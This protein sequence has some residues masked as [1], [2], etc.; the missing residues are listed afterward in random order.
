[1]TNQYK[2][3]KKYYYTLTLR[4]SSEKE[5]LHSS[6]TNIYLNNMVFSKGDVFIDN[7]VTKKGRCYVNPKYFKLY[8]GGLQCIL[9]G[10]LKLENEKFN[11]VNIGT[12]KYCE[13]TT[14]NNIV[15]LQYV[16]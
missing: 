12:N 14:E 10:I 4:D 9:P 15:K 11:E 1:V 5:N 6:L 3:H 13:F 8:N 7:N 2:T 16:K